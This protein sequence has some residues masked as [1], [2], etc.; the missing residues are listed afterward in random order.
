MEREGLPQGIE[1]LMQAHA[2]MGFASL[3]DQFNTI[4]ANNSFT[5]LGIAS[6]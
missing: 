3:G 2:V 4:H 5:C 1:T 6:R